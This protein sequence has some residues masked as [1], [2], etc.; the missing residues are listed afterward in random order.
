MMID[1][2][3]HDL[4]AYRAD[5]RGTPRGAI[6]V[7]QEIWGLVD[8]IKD[9]CDRVAAEGYVAIAPDLVGHLGLTPEAGQELQRLLTDPDPAVRNRAQ[10]DVRDKLATARTPEFTAWAIPALRAVADHALAIEGVDG[11]LGSVGFCFGGTW[12]YAL[13]IEEPRLR[14]AVVFYGRYPAERDHPHCPVLAFYGERDHSITDLVPELN[15]RMAA[16]GAHVETLVYPAVGH[17]FFND[18]NP[19]AYDAAT[20]ADAWRRTLA[21]WAEHL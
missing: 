16:A 7:L 8:H 3:D 20:A 2:A 11:R 1:L 12:S 4:V 17:A 9:V 18:T 21:F 5:P 13:S 15:Q 14:A 19:H 10:P 6:I